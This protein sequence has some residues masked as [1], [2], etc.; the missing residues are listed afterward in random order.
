M[1]KVVAA[2]ALLL[3]T[4]CGSDANNQAAPAAAKSSGVDCVSGTF[5]G[6]GSSAQK[7]AVVAWTA[8]YQQQC[9]DV[10]FNY[11]AQG[12]NN[13]RTQFIQKQVPLAGSDASLVEPQRTQAQGR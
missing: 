5:N 7:P 6:A 1:P 9:P 3:L 2:A 13:G 8:A 4:A 11:D 12:S 10:A